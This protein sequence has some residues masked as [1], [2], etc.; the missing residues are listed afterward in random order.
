MDFI[1]SV[2]R[3]H[4]GSDVVPFE[5]T[6]LALHGNRMSDIGFG[7]W[8]E[9]KQ[10]DLLRDLAGV[11]MWSHGGLDQVEGGDD[12]Q[13]ALYPSISRSLFI[14]T[15]LC[16]HTSLNVCITREYFGR[17]SEEDR[18]LDH[19]SSPWSQTR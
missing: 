15:S 19:I 1:Q 16:R 9:C 17:W 7:G 18:L 5:R 12:E 10:R 2:M 6:I 4:L 13:G 8:T 3:S 14:N 11:H